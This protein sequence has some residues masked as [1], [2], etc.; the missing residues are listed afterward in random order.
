MQFIRS[1]LLNIFF[2]QKYM[3]LYN[4]ENKAA[5]D[6]YQSFIVET[7][8]VRWPV[9]HKKRPKPSMYFSTKFAVRELHTNLEELLKCG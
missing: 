4:T 1:L 7:K 5:A 9:S 2:T 8:V 3:T 6:Y